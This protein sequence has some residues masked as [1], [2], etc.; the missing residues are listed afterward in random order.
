MGLITVGRPCQ[1]YAPPLLLPFP[2]L[3]ALCHWRQPKTVNC[4]SWSLLKLSGFSLLNFQLRQCQHLVFVRWRSRRD[5]W[6]WGGPLTWDFASLIAPL[7]Q[8][9]VFL[10]PW[11]R[12]KRAKV[13][14]NSKQ[15][16]GECF[17]RNRPK[18]IWIPCRYCN[19]NIKA[20]FWWSSFRP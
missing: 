11:T 3:V 15:I 16:N 20:F 5:G 14:R 19:L 10:L 13:S 9:L 12:S 6:G 18:S 7:L 17:R 4:V 2:S 1:G 8:I